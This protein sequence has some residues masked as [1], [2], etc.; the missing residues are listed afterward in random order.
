[1]ELSCVT[2]PLAR[3]KSERTLLYTN[4]RELYKI[5]AEIFFIADAYNQ[6]INIVTV[7]FCSKYS[8]T[9]VDSLNF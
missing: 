2:L 6:K 4:S 8:K 3:I 5:N 1:M 7:K 9:H